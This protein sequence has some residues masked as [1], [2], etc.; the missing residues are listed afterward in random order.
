MTTA[1]PAG[2]LIRH[3]RI[4]PFV[5]AWLWSF[6]VLF[7]PGPDLPQHVDVWDKLGHASL[8]AAIALTGR[9][10]RVPAR[11]V[12]AILVGYAAISEVLQ[13]QLPIH[14]DGDW[15]DSLADIIG[16]VCALAVW[17]GAVRLVALV[18]PRFR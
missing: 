7:T 17:A 18:R 10:A 4:A 3:W 2:G 13:W 14:R 1:S 12:L 11:W 5:L 15:H 6:L 16:T 9:F 8:F